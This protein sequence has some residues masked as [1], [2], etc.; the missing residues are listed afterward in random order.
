MARGSGKSG[1][2]K[3]A[4]GNGAN[5]GF[6]AKLRAVADALGNNMDAAE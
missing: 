4:R 1:K 3:S 5:L 6:A 2:G